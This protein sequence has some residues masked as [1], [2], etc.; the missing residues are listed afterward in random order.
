[1]PRGKLIALEG[2]DG[3]GKRTQMEMLTRAIERR[4]TALLNLSF[5]RYDGFFGRLVARYLNGD[6]GT[7]E[8][9]DAHFSALLYAGDRLEARPQI[10]AALA[11]GHLV[12]ADRYIASNLAHQGARVEPG[13]RKEFLEWL[14]RLEY[15]VYGLPAED[16]VVYLRVPAAEAQRLV[17]GKGARE[18]THLERDLQE[19]NFAHMQGASQVYDEL[20]QAANWVTIECLDSGGALR[21]PAEVHRAVLATAEARVLRGAA[22]S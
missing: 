4:G 8:Q 13:R 14:R 2:I 11:Q 17:S 5:P 9:V 20:A 6:F 18:Y 3:S 21:S 7:L 1:M 12:L 10:E 19:A 15:Q 22:S 16:L